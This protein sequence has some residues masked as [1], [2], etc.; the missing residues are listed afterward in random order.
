VRTEE[1]LT[2]DAA[3]ELRKL[4]EATL[5]GPWQVPA[6]LVRRA[7]IGGARHVEV[8]LARR[9]VVV[10]DDGPP[11]LPA[12]VHALARLLDA[13]RPAAERH[14]AV[15]A[16]EDD[17]ELLAV[18]ALRT[19][20]VH[21]ARDG[22]RNEIVIEG[23]RLDLAAAARWL[24][25]AVRFA[26]AT[27]LLGGERL[28]GGFAG[29]MAEAPL[30]D[31]LGGRLALTGDETAHLWLLW[32][33]VVSTHLT[34][35]DTP[36]FEAAVEMRALALSRTPAALREAI[37][38]HLGALADQAVALLLARAAAGGASR[39]VRTQLLVAARRGWRR[40][41]V[42]RAPLFPARVGGAPVTLRLADLGGTGTFPCLDPG[43]DVDAVL[44]PAGP[45]L[46]LDADE[47]GRLSR[48]L[49]VRFRPVERRRV[50]AGGRA[51][52][53]RG[54]LRLRAAASRIFSRI[55]HPRAGA[56]LPESAL[57]ADE[58]RFLHVL[59]TVR[60][61]ATVP[62]TFAGGRGPIRAR[63]GSVCLPR[64]NA[65]VAAAVRAV[66]RDPQRIRAAMVMLLEP[67]EA[68]P[69]R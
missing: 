41:E 65:E 29:A 67:V 43:E 4:A 45:T 52:L 22:R 30:G 12:R 31:P 37:E 16:L 63:P 42:F 23:A 18:A 55:L 9:R 57:S 40:G 10:R 24:R 61:P 54:F 8:E 15:L 50:R 68:A 60:G 69:G 26:R 66:A 64:A 28:G 33:G 44:L 53:R 58:R 1:L 47:R 62:V 7:L 14:E 35:P 59:D 25:A 19:P 51:R 46:L 17:P 5:E 32:G 3:S 38:P 11:L 21:V 34:L 20:D 27:V 56:T 13:S 39:F 2:I 36:A 49:G 48:L 6:E